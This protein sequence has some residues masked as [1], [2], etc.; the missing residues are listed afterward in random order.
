MSNLPIISYPISIARIQ[1]FLARSYRS[2][3]VRNVAVVAS[4]TA[5]AQ[6]IT[7]AFSPVITRFYGPEAFGLLGVFLSAQ[8]ILSQVGALTYPN[9][10]VLPKSDNEAKGIARLSAYI[11]FTLAM[12]VAVILWT[13]GEHL[14][15]LL[16][17]QEI[18]RFAFLLPLAMLFVSFTQICLQWLIRKKQFGVSTR[19]GVINT[20]IVNSS[21]VGVGFFYPLAGVLIVLSAMGHALY[22]GMLALAIKKFRPL[23]DKYTNATDTKVNLWYLAKKYYDFPFYR[24]PQVLINSISHNLPLLMLAAYFGPAP[25]GFFTLCMRVLGIPSQLLANSVSAVFYPR[26]TEAAHRG[27]NLTKLI[28]KATFLLA[29]V[30][31]APFALLIAFGP[32]L[33]SFVFGAEWVSAGQYARWMAI[34]SFFFFINKPSVAAVPVLGLQ[35]GLLIYEFFSTG[36]KV[37]AIYIGAI[38][39]SDDQLAIAFFS[40]FGAIAYI[41]LIAWV[42]ISSIFF[43]SRVN[44]ETKTG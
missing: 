24:A 39:F 27:E 22:A 12:L 30:G 1:N 25:A 28:L 32:W 40:I 44:N 42:I 13:V 35:K 29:A 34:M 14:L 4:G 7:I 41:A 33:F 8:G 20:L 15:R 43:N 21:K 37:V 6:A 11:A 5:A 17:A 2:R 31:F 18:Y 10:I 3:F 36:S 19:V 38:V 9:A 16:D 23:A 26:I